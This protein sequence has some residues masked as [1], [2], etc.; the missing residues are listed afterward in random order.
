M[1]TKAFPTLSSGAKLCLMIVVLLPLGCSHISSSQAEALRITK[2]EVVPMLGRS[3]VIIV[4]VRSAQSWE[5]GERK[6]AGSV[7]EDR[8][9]GSDAWMGKYPKDRILI[10][11][12]A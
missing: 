12:C 9:D 8:K 5:E 3:D 7:R 1:S 2:E 11:Y 4:D 6:I 10:F